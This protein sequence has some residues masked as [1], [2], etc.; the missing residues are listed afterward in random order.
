LSQR[1]LRQAVGGATVALVTPAWEEPYGLV[2]AEA[3][4][5]GTPVAAFASGAMGE[6][7]DEETGRLVAPGDTAALASAMHEASGLSRERVRAIAVEKWGL[8]RMVDQ[9]EAIYYSMSRQGAAA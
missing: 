9:Y 1:D 2:A 4:S 7:I 3:M 5:C 8:V 6:L